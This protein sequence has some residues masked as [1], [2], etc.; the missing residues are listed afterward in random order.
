MGYSGP[1]LQPVSATISST[2]KAEDMAG[3]CIDGETGGKLCHTKSES[4]PWLAIDYGQQVIIKSVEIFNRRGQ[5]ANRLKNVDIRVAEERPKSDYGNEMFT[6]GQLF[7]H[8][9]GP[10]ENG[11]EILV[12]GQK[13]ISKCK[14]IDFAY[15]RCTDIREVRHCPNE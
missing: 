11:E 8:F 6:G 2:N 4:A 1:V 7:G 13:H 5:Y 10:A 14:K 9:K 3:N 12:T 15:Y